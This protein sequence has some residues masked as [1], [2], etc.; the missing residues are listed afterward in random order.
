M[1]E[2]KNVQDQQLTSRGM[3][4]VRPLGEKKKD[5]QQFHKTKLLLSIYR[6]V[7]WRIESAIYEIQE[8]AQE[9]GSDRI[10]ELIDF[11]S[12]ELDEYD[13]TEDRKA[14]EE[15]LMCIAETKQMIEIV[16]KALKH[17][18]THPK[19]G[20]VYHDIIIYCYI[21]KEVLSDDIIMKRLTLSQST[22]YRYKKQATELM[23]IALWGYIIPPLK[24]YWERIQQ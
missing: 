14:I 11:L 20:Q 17:L 19:Y 18:K 1:Q 23:G 13:L 12:L 24:E 2:E 22:Y 16:D 10:S 8:S 15:R 21:D 9:Y 7:V 4:G 5:T 3:K 6:T